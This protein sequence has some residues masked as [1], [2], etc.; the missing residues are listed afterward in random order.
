MSKKRKPRELTKKEQ[1]LVDSISR[2]NKYLIVLLVAVGSYLAYTQW[3]P[4]QP[5]LAVE[6]LAEEI[7]DGID[8][9]T[10]FIAEGNY[11]LVKQNCISCHSSKLVI[12][13]RMSYE[14]WKNSIVWMQETQNLHDL[15]ENEE[16]ILAYL[17]KYYAPIKTGRRKP[18][19]IE[20]W[21]EIPS[22]T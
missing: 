16:A 18:L 1:A 3:F 6:E 19:I 9:A 13:N 14:G 2:L 12:Q 15:G 21:Y 20:E 4:P 7:V 17:A 5:E 11:K 10:G 22:G 8:V